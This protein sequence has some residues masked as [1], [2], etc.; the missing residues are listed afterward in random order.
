MNV[1][2]CFFFSLKSTQSFFDV[3]PTETEE[4][5]LQG[6]SC[7]CNVESNINEDELCDDNANYFPV[8]NEEER[9]LIESYSNDDESK[10]SVDG[11][12]WYSDSIIDHEYRSYFI[13]DEQA[14]HAMNRI[15]SKRS[16]R[17][18][19][20]KEGAT[21]YCR[22]H[23]EESEAGRTCKDIYEKSVENAMIQCAN[24][25]KVLNTVSQ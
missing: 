18:L 8:L 20:T 10:R 12:Y 1:I 21:E 4:E 11:S 16:L 19:M 14:Q 25:L 17:V 22:T 2:N 6:R 23:I 15:R 7:Y 5:S 9:E 3:L 13:D 24:D